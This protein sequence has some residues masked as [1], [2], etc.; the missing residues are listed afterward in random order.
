[1][2]IIF[3]MKCYTTMLHN[4]SFFGLFTYF[5]M[6]F[7]YPIKRCF[8]FFPIS[9]NIEFL[10]EWKWRKVTQV[11]HRNSNKYCY[12]DI[13]YDQVKNRSS[14]CIS[15]H[16]ARPFS[17]NLASH[18]NSMFTNSTS[19]HKPQLCRP[20]RWLNSKELVD[21]MTKKN[22]SSIRQ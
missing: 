15:P 8:Y 3:L 11:H 4:N 21:L 5:W 2:L 7:S 18:K 22:S 1:M 9:D 12:N 13:L 20:I 10:D 16:G 6:L 17:G 19:R 14:A